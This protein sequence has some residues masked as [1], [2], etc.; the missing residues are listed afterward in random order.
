MTAAKH[1]HAAIIMSDAQCYNLQLQL[2]QVST[3]MGHIT[4]MS[5]QYA[6]IT[7]ISLLDAL[8]PHFA[9][10]HTSFYFSQ[11]ISSFRSHGSNM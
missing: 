2:N 10:Q 8:H 4:Q 7:E 1:V 9:L 3:D 11:T 6:E 5:N